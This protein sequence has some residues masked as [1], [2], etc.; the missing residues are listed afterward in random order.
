MTPISSGALAK[1]LPLAVAAGLCG[2]L[3]AGAAA[4]WAAYGSAVFFEMI[5]AG[6]RAC[7]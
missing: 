3:L 4:L 2:V 1:S 6:F 7:F 5:A